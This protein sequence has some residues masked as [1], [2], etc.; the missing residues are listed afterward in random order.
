MERDS[1]KAP[2]QIAVRVFEHE[3]FGFIEARDDGLGW[4]VADK[5]RLTEPYMTTREKGTGLGLAIVRRVMEDHGGRLDL[6]DPA[7][8]DTG[9]VVRL[10]FPLLETRA[11][12][13]SPQARAEA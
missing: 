5:A 3:G 10:A 8:G 2:G 1:A 12:L 7:P 9:A 4:P 13:D 6:D 11:G